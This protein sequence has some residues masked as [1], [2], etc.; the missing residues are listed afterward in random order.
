MRIGT[1]WLAAEACHQ[2][3]NLERVGLFHHPPGKAGAGVDLDPATACF[4]R[5]TAEAFMLK[6]RSPSPSSSGVSCGLAAISPQTETGIRIRSAASV[7]NCTSRS[8]AGMQRVV[9]LGDIGLAAV[10][11]QRVRRQVVG[12]DREEIRLQRQRIGGQARRPAFRS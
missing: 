7:A 12:A 3:G 6:L 2:F 5:G 11:R 9:Q 8:T 10:H 4:T 1:R